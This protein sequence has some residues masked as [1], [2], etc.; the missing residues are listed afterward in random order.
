MIYLCLIRSQTCPR[1]WGKIISWSSLEISSDVTA[2][3]RFELKIYTKFLFTQISSI[4]QLSQTRKT[5]PLRKHQFFSHLPFLVLLRDTNTLTHIT[6]PA[7]NAYHL[8][9]AEPSHNG[10]LARLREIGVHMSKRELKLT[11]PTSSSLVQK[12]VSLLLSLSLLL[13]ISSYKSN[14]IFFFKSGELGW[15]ISP[16][17]L[18][19]WDRF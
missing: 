1:V 12:T 16:M 7:T 9:I 4:A 10:G 19:I 11:P 6:H 8:L 5:S 3:E 15:R 14:T 17:Q 18:Q 13:S 2:T